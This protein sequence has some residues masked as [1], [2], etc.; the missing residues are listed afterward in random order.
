[1]GAH[2]WPGYRCG[3]LGEHG[4]ICESYASTPSQLG[5]ALLQQDTGAGTSCASSL[6]VVSTSK[7][8][9]LGIVETSISDE[10][11]EFVRAHESFLWRWRPHT[12]DLYD[13]RPVGSRSYS[14]Y[15]L[16]EK[17]GPAN[18]VFAGD[19]IAA[20]QYMSLEVGWQGMCIRMLHI[21]QPC[22]A[23]VSWP[24]SCCT[25]CRLCW[26]TT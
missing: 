15:A 2:R 16:L 20:E 14:L 1:M 17:L 11:E 7:P 5:T 18:I 22:C 9:P 23:C 8:F 4:R 10:Q 26:G 3:R 24:T 6:L 12:C 25:V 13:F 21:R 19:S